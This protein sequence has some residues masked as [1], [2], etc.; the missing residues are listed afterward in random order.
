MP[1]STASQ[2]KQTRPVRSTRQ[3][4][5]AEEHVGQS[6]PR[7]LPSKGKATLEPTEVIPVETPVSQDKL[8]ALA[9][10]EEVVT[11]LVHESTNPTDEP[12]PE[13]WVDGR[14]Q[15]FLRGHEQ[16]V[17]RKYVEA[18]ARAK[19][20]TY[21]QVKLPDNAGYKN[22][23]HTALRYPFSVTQ[24]ANPRGRDWLKAILAQA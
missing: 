1:R 21:S 14:A 6:R 12:M 22:V 8:A 2:A 19:K 13:V 17:K 7:V 5:D 11:I 23:P 15:R 10:N 3:F 24:D 18:L 20:T 9:F 4:L 16:P